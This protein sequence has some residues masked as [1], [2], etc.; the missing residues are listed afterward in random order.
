MAVVVEVA[1]SDRFPARP[2]IGGHPAADDAGP[3]HVPDRGLAIGVLPQEVGRPSPLKSP[4][5]I[6]QLGPGSGLTVP[7]AITAV[8]SIPQIAARPSVF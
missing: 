6:F 1:G 7:P 3:V 8:P 4:V 5:P 2:R